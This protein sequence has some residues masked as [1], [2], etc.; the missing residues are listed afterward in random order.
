MSIL[1]LLGITTAYA[2]E[3]GTVARSGFM[4]ILPMLI[5]IV[6]LMYFMIIR[7]QQKR[8]KEQK[9]LL[10]SIKKGDEIVTTGGIL[11]EVVK[12]SE[13]FVVLKISEETEITIQKSS[14]AVTVPKG[15]IKSV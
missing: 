14:V 3:Q 13:N 9:V 15:T 1:N 7:P 8:A 4:S 6:L 2:A 12:V 11:G 10:G 5:I